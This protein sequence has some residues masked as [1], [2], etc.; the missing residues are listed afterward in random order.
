MCAGHSPGMNL[1]SPPKCPNPGGQ[2]AQ[3]LVL[4]MHVCH[5]L[6]LLFAWLEEQT[7]QD[8][9]PLA[10]L[11]ETEEQTCRCSPRFQIT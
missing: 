3:A 2:G 8:E 7:A 9:H 5:F 4:L 10:T 11:E 1:S 6:T